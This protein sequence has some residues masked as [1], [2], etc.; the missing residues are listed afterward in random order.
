M[1]LPSVVANAVPSHSSLGLRWRRVACIQDRAAR[2][3]VVPVLCNDRT[4]GRVIAR[5]SGPRAS[6]EPYVLSSFGGKPNAIARSLTWR[7]HN[8]VRMNQ[9]LRRRMPPARRMVNHAARAVL[10]VLVLVGVVLLI[11]EILD[12]RTTAL[13]LLALIWLCEFFIFV[14]YGSTS[15]MDSLHS[16]TD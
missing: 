3:L 11:S 1:A 9:Q 15:L 8:T 12:D 6:M 16:F 2:L 5:D 4:G 13:L 10:Y 14:S 7:I